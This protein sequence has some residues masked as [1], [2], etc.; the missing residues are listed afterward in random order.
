MS[1]PQQVA[2]NLSNSVRSHVIFERDFY[3]TLG[4]AL[5]TGLIISI[6]LMLLVL[7]LAGASALG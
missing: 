4:A 3:V 6:G 2:R 7:L 5:G 1:T